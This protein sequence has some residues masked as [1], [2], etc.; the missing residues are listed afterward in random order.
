MRRKNVKKA[1]FCKQNPLGWHLTYML[2]GTT[3]MVAMTVTTMDMAGSWW[4][5][6]EEMTTAM[7]TTTAVMTTTTAVTTTT[8]VMTT[9][10]IVSV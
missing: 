2:A 3:T 6:T 7:E 9:T 1:F 10:G 4:T 8:G 5:T